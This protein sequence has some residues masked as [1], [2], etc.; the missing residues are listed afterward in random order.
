MNTY[1]LLLRVGLQIDKYKFYL[2]IYQVDADRMGDEEIEKI[3]T[4]L[5]YEWN[6]GKDDDELVRVDVLAVSKLD[7]E[8]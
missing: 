8:E 3:R 7:R 5:E 1:L 2:D 4:R 6:I